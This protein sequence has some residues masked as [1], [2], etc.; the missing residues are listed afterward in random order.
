ML[1]I[2]NRGELSDDNMIKLFK[3]RNEEIISESNMENPSG[4]INLTSIIK[5]GHIHT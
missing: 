5:R 1:Y 3:T 4:P 2:Y